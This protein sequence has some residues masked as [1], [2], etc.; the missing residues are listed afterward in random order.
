VHGILLRFDDRDAAAARL[1]DRSTDHDGSAADLRAAL[2][3]VERAYDEFALGTR[4]IP[5]K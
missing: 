5:V 1:A 3:D 2:D 4:V